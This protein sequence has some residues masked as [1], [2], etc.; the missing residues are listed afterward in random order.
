M[1]RFE[2]NLM[3]LT[4]MRTITLM[5]H[6]WSDLWSTNG[7]H[8]R[9]LYGGRDAQVLWHTFIQGNVPVNEIS[10]SYSAQ[11]ANTILLRWSTNVLNKIVVWCEGSTSYPDAHKPST[12]LLYLANHHNSS[13]SVDLNIPRVS[14]RQTTIQSTDFVNNR[15]DWIPHSLE[16][17]WNRYSHTSLPR[18]TDV[19]IGSRPTRCRKR[20]HGL[21]V[22]R[23]MDTKKTHNPNRSSPLLNTSERVWRRRL[24]T[25][26]NTALVH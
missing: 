8:Q 9:T 4:Q 23:P 11:I 21:R 7:N 10:R 6:M 25:N 2:R 13:P 5:A 1:V 12:L 17:C 22:V 16:K 18:L 14:A 3:R 20:L 15:L 24:P 26:N 19:Q